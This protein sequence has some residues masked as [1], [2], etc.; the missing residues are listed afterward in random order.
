METRFAERLGKVFSDDHGPLM[1][2]SIENTEHG[3]TIF[4]YVDGLIEAKDIPAI[5]CEDGYYEFWERGQ[6]VNAG[7]LA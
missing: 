7:S 2:D 6:F 1:G 5:E 3:E 4:R